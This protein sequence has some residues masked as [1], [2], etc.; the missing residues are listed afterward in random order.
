MSYPPTIARPALG[1]S[2]PQSIRIMVVLPDPFGPS[3]PKISPCGIERST[4]STA[5]R[6][7]NFFVR[8]SATIAFP[9]AASGGLLL[10]PDRAQGAEEQNECRERGEVAQQVR[11]RHPLQRQPPNGFP[12][13]RHREAGCD[14]AA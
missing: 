7:P 13:I 11:R 14:R 5:R 6:E 2:T 8:P 12:G 10:Q 4:R 1:A 9:T 3:N